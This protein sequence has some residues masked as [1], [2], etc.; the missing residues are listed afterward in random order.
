[1]PKRLA[2]GKHLLFLKLNPGPIPL[3]AQQ[4]QQGQQQGQ[5]QPVVYTAPTIDKARLC[6]CACSL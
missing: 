5:Q 4:Q 6:A 1:M 2:K 3:V